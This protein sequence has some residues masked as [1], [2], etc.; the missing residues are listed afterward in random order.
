MQ[1][2]ILYTSLT[3]NTQEAVDV[4]SDALENIDAEVV[5]FDADDGIAADEFFSDGDAY[6]LA[7]YTD[8]EGELPD[9]VLDLA[10]DLADIDLNGL[11]VAVLGTGD[12]SY[13]YFC[14]AVDELEKL[15]QQAGGQLIAPSVKIEMAPDDA[16]CDAI[17]QFAQTVVTQAQNLS[18]N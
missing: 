6:V 15:V 11:P 12:T 4:L 5:A 17:A 7:S 2:K 14:G 10:D 18:E 16:A 9:G 1:V 3:G 8:G 13:E